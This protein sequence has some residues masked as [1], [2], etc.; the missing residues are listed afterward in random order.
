[1]A[2]ESLRYDELLN[3]IAHHLS[4]G[5]SRDGGI[6]CV[7][8][9]RF[10]SGGE[11]YSKTED[12]LPEDRLAL[13]RLMELHFVELPDLHWKMS[14]DDI[15]AFL[16]AYRSIK[17]RPMKWEPRIYSKEDRNEI[18]LRWLE[19]R[20]KHN[21][22]LA[23]EIAQGRIRIFDADRMPQSAPQ[24]QVHSF[25]TR[26][27]A[28]AYLESV[29][30]SLRAIFGEVVSEASG[31]VSPALIAADRSNHHSP[32]DSSPKTQRSASAGAALGAVA[33]IQMDSTQSALTAKD[34]GEESN[35]RVTETS[36]ETAKKSRRHYSLQQRTLAISY[37]KTGD[38]LGGARALEM[39]PK[40]FRQNAKRWSEESDAREAEA[41]ASARSAHAPFGVTQVRDGKAPR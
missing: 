27:D 5:P 26:K 32:S 40:L 35:P 37:F 13:Q 6:A 24:P 2:M 34:F 17:D 7:W 31:D 38:I 4:P 15:K 41:R 22:R 25:L 33:A 21:A 8:G 3:A 20:N 12:L 23:Q 16:E 39:G 18:A 30:L 29:G 10:H 1:M 28:Q 14:D 19:V 36:T 9:K 11:F